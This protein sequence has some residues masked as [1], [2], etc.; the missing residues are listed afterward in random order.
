MEEDKKEQTENDK[1]LF[2]TNEQ[3]LMNMEKWGVKPIDF[4]FTVL[5][6]E[7]GEVAGAYLTKSGKGRPTHQKDLRTEIIHAAAVLK[8]MYEVVCE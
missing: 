4:L 2:L 8:A 3:H 5:M 7:V 6:E 1:F